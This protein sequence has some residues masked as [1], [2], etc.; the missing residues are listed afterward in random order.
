M[1]RPSIFKLAAIA[2]FYSTA[3]SAANNNADAA[4]IDAPAVKAWAV[5][6]IDA[7]VVNAIDVAAAN[8]WVANVMVA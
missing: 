2:A 1:R 3:I 8:A 7:P 6:A 5:K 4:V